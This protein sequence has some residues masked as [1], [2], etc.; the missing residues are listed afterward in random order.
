[1]CDNKGTRY[2]SRQAR[3]LRNS[4][5]GE[6][7]GTPPVPSSREIW[8]AIGL[9]LLFVALLVIVIGWGV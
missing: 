3:E 7:N 4:I 1:M 8:A 2:L 6:D 5:Y 9:L